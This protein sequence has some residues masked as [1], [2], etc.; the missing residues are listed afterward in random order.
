MK[1]AELITQSKEEQDKALAPARAEEQKAALGLAISNQQLSLKG[2]QNRVAELSGKYPLDID[3]IIS[4]NDDLD[5]E[6]RRL[7][8][9][10]TLSDSLFDTSVVASLTAS[11]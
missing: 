3:A 10:A 8:Q 9:L 2:R 5:L 6:T 1:Y 4:A 11:A 7:R